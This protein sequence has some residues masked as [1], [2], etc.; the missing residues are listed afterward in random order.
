MCLFIFYIKTENNVKYSHVAMARE[1]H[2]T[3]TAQKQDLSPT[4]FII[5]VV[6][7]SEN[8]SR[9]KRKHSRLL[10]STAKALA[11]GENKTPVG[12]LESPKR[13]SLTASGMDR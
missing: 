7:F 10:S 2:L 3:S 8:K 1:Y 13:Y 12:P 4:V 6:Y 5:P 9:A 11:P